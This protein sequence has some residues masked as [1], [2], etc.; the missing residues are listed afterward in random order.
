[1]PSQPPRILVVDDNDDNLMLLQFFL[2]AEGYLVETVNSGKLVLSKIRA[3]SPDLVLLDV[4]MPE[5]NGY[6]VTKAIRQEAKLQSLPIVLITADTRINREQSLKV[7]A[8]DVLPKPVDFN[9]LLAILHQW[10]NSRAA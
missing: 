4:M 3:T 5:V 8:N 2:E 7:G 1:M 6:E 10:C 9:L